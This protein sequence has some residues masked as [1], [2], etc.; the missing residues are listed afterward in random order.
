[1]NESTFLNKIKK[2]WEW[3]KKI[4]DNPQN[5]I[6]KLYSQSRSLTM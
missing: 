1:M 4:R 6:S 5:G 2:K 3:L